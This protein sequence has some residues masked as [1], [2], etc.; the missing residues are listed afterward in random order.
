ML[1]W[2]DDASSPS[3][4]KLPLKR[5]GFG[6]DLAEKSAIPGKVA[7]FVRTRESGVSGAVGC[8]IG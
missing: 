7:P 4:V 8:P 1:D 5:P 6:R 3:H 2:R